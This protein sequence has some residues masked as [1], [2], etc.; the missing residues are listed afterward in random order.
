MTKGGAGAYI[1][2]CA[3]PELSAAERAFFADADPLGF[4]LFSRNVVDPAQLRRLTGDLRDSVGRDAMILVDQEG[5]RVQRLCPPH[6]QAW[7][8]P[9]DE[10]AAAAPRA[11]EVMRLRYQMIAA[12]LREVGIDVNCAPCA[13]IARPDTHDVL[14]NRCYG[15]DAARVTGIARA[16]AEGLLAGGVLPVLKHMPGHGMARVDSHKALPRVTLPRPDLEAQDFAPFR[17][18]ADLPLAMTAHVV[19]D[20]IDAERPATQSPDMVA[21]MRG[22]IG[23]GGLLMTDDISMQALSGPVAARSQAALAAGCDVVLHCN[24]DLAEMRAVAESC[25]VLSEQGVS[26]AGAALALRRAPPGDIRELA[27]RWEA[28]T[29]AS[30]HG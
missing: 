17:A 3:G 20:A 10:V 13:D 6:W 28:L 29:G 11:A 15:T 14:W 18:L 8:A 5:G 24:G 21:L 27:A 19:F 4:I 30:A 9:M 25:G 12:E 1:L 7:R 22:A 16:V 26:R 2:G 23:F